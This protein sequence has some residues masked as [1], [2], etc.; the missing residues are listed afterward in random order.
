MNPFEALAT[1]AAAWEEIRARLAPDAEL[2]AHLRALREAEAGSEARAHA[3]ARAAGALARL[4]PER[5]AAPSEPRGA[6]TAEEVRVDGFDAADLAVLL[7]DGHRMAG[8][9]LGVVRERLL[10][11]PALGEEAVRR[12]GGDPGAPGLIRLPGPGGL[13]RLPAFQF[14]PDGLPWS[15]V[16]EVNGLLGAEEDPWGSADWWL[17]AN[18]WLEGGG[19]PARLVGAGADGLL[20]AAAGQ[21][22][23]GE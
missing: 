20:I 7:L 6:A 12:R 13:A 10:A 22:G 3:A 18:A 11:V 8:P 9:V 5:F 1:A 23:A 21:L 14:A 16:V 17:S 19:V 2:R 4:L 15:V